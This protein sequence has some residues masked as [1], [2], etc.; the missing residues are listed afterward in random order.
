MNLATLKRIARDC[1]AER[2]DYPRTRDWLLRLYDRLLNRWPWAPFPFRKKICA[3]HK[4]GVA[5]PFAVRLGSSDW[6][7]LNEVFVNDEYEALLK[8]DV[9]NP[10]WIVDLGSNIG[11]TLRLWR[12]NYPEARILAVEPDPDNVRVL[13]RNVAQIQDGQI[14][15][16]QACVLGYARPVH[17]QQGAGEWA[18]SVRDNG[19]ET[20]TPITAFTMAE[21]LDKHC[22]DEMIDVLKCDIEGTEKE[23]FRDCGAW[24]KR[25]RFA[26][27]ELHGDY[28]IKDLKRDTTE[29]GIPVEILWSEERDDLS[30]A[31]FRTLA[32]GSS[33]Q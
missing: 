29:S 3:I 23:L 7:L 30:L 18:Y 11:L 22:R 21:L 13:Q 10:R 14:I 2:N 5:E 27:V 9:G 20:S 12:Q 16:E 28:R 31:L 15:L 1:R 19:A 4:K 25:V 6:H 24:L 17:L 26:M 32:N 33:R 8:S